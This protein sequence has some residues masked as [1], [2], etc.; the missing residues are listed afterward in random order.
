MSFTIRI[1]YKTGCAY[2][3]LTLGVHTGSQHI[4]IC[5]ASDKE[6]VIMAEYGLRPTMEKRALLKARKVFRQ[7]HWYKK[8]R[9]RQ[10]NVSARL[11][12][13]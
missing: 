4:G 5:T 13:W 1:L 12:G 9:Y 6:A 2:E 3:E 11:D 8:V 10:P 7:G